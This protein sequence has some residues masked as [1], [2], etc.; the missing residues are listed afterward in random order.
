MKRRRLII[1]AV[2]PLTVAGLWMYRQA[3][4]SEGPTYRVATV[5]RGDVESAVSAT[6][7]LSAITTVQVGTQVS[8]QVSAIAVDFNDRVRPST[9]RSTGSWSSATSTSGRPW[10]RACRRHSSS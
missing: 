10:P 9:R 4:G 7:S 8:G 1:A 6:G 3:D 2:L 5:E